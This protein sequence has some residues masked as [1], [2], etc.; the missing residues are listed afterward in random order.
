MPCLRCGS[1][2]RHKVVAGRNLFWCGN[3]Q[4]RT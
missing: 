3:C 1:T 2:V 4:R